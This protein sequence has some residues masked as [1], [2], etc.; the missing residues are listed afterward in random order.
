MLFSRLVELLGELAALVM[1]T[2]CRLIDSPTEIV[3]LGT[4]PEVEGGRVVQVLD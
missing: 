4:M 1:E 2:P 3:D